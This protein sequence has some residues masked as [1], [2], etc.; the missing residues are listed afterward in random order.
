MPDLS[1]GQQLKA[2]GNGVSPQQAYVA[3]KHL[4]EYADDGPA[5]ETR[6]N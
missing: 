2:V 3:Y 1:R 6:Q 4:L 5:G